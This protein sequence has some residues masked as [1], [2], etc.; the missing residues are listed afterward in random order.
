VQ[1]R[2]LRSPLR[3]S[4]GLGALGW[5]LLACSGDGLVLPGESAPAAI[6][7][8]KGDGQSAVVGTPLAD[9]LAVRITDAR[10]RP[11]ANQRVAFV[12]T[13]AGD[14]QSLPDTTVTGAD[15]VAA[16][17]WILGTT[18][19]TQ[20]LEARVVGAPTPLKAAFTASAMPGAPNAL[21]I[22]IQPSSSA[23]SGTPFAQQPRLQIVDPSG[24][25]V[26]QTGVSVTAAVASGTGGTLAGSTAIATDPTGLAT[27]VDLTITG[28]AGSYTLL[29]ASNGLTAVTSSP[30]L[31]TVSGPILTPTRSAIASSPNPSN[32]GQ[33]VTFTATV[34]SG[35]GTPTGNVRFV[36]GTCAAPTAALSGSL[37]LSALG[38]AR[39]RISKLSA[40]TH[41]VL[42]C[43]DGGTGFAP[44]VGGPLDQ[45]VNSRP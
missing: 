33:R 12:V 11:I 32:E 25:A 27:F 10:G 29:F 45:V 4:R 17:R 24:N 20:A 41:A 8:V 43:Y 34:T 15:G 44:S 38:T 9:S 36:E 14:G 31:V 2:P 30:I 35:A 7:V 40:G 37:A 1:V 19:G 21:V 23:P 39:L 26:A 28:P 6:A 16:A 42:L 3:R 13:A 22:Q 5:L 18:I